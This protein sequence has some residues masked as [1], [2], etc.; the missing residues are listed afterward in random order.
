M[1]NKTFQAGEFILKQNDIGHEAY[2]ILKGKVEVFVQMGNEKIVL[3]HAGPDEIL[4]E[5]GMIGDKPRSASA[6]AME[7]TEVEVITPQEFNQLILSQPDKLL[8]YLKTFFERLRRVTDSYSSLSSQAAS[9]NN[10]SSISKVLRLKAKTELLR[11]RIPQQEVILLK[12]P[13][14]IGRWAEDSQA[15]VFVSNDLL[16]RDEK[17]FVIS[18]NHC[19]IEKEGTRF[20]VLDR[21]SAFG[22]RVNGKVIGGEESQVVCQL[23]KGLNEIQLGRKESPYIFELTVS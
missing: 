5:M 6:V 23:E 15:D 7:T 16:I 17:P 3:G 18:R 13:F 21:G 4:G 1:Q 14:R 22:T 8:P 12:F 10:D 19:A 9:A 11:L 2:R 20:Y